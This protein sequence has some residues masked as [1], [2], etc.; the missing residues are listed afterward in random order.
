MAR[1]HAKHAWR[2][3]RG[4]KIY[5]RISD[6]ELLLLAE[7]GHLRRGDLLWKPGIGGW[8]S[9]ESVQDILAPPTLPTVQSLTVQSAATKIGAVLSAMWKGVLRLEDKL[10]L[11]AKDHARSIKFPLRRAYPRWPSFNSGNFL[12]MQHQKTLAGLLILLVFVGSIVAMRASFAIGTRTP[13]EKA[14]SPKMPDRQIAAVAPDTAKPVETSNPSEARPAIEPSA[15]QSVSAAQPD[16]VSNPPSASQSES[17]AQ[18]DLVPPT[19]SVPQSESGAQPDSIPLPTRKPARPTAREA[20]PSTA[21]LNRIARR[22]REPEPMRFGSFGYNY[23]P[24]Q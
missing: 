15:S 5:S 24:P 16:A 1:A 23:N 19:V 14:A 7:L 13:I 11:I 8:R 18:S 22:Q 12:R 17:G 6:R 10:T 21:V 9:V 20:L 2:L 3:M 4:Q